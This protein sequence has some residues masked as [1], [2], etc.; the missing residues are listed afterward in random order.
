[1]KYMEKDLFEFM[2]AKRP[3]RVT[4]KSGRIYTG[5]CWAYSKGFNEEEDGVSEPSLEV[6][7]TS[8]YLSEIEII[9]YM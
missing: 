4:S 1:M 2:D 7:N 5:M 3:V 9:E 8:L 6:G